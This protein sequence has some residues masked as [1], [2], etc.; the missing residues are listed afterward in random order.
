MQVFKDFTEDEI[1]HI[2]NEYEDFLT[3][4]ACDCNYAE[5]DNWD[6]GDW[7]EFEDMIMEVV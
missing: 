1:K 6:S 3:R 2:R 7:S 4:M 5:Y